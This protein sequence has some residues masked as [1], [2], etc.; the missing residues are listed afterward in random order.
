MAV[1]VIVGTDKGGMLLRSDDVREH[2]EL[3]ELGFR[4][5]RVTSAARDPGGRTYL[6]VAL[7]SFGNA[8]LDSW[9]ELPCTL[10]KILCVEAFRL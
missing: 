7:E 2:W 8:V 3:G 5:W 6:A 9:I 4:D 10:P 1:V